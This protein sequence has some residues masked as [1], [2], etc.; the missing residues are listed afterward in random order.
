MVQSCIIQEG[1]KMMFF[2]GLV[3]WIVLMAIL[4]VLVIKDWKWI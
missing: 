2:L 3:G 4:W 1:V